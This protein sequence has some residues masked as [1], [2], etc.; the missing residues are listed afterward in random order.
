MSP[1]V[2]KKSAAQV[3]APPVERL[4]GSSQVEE[5]T[6]GAAQLPAHP[7]HQLAPL[8]LPLLPEDAQPRIPGGILPGKHPA[9]VRRLGEHQPDRLPQ[10]PGQVRHRGVHRNHQVQKRDQRGGI[11]E[12]PDPSSQVEEFQPRRGG[13]SL[14]GSRAKL[15]GVELHPRD[16]AQRGQGFQGAGAEGIRHGFPAPDDPHSESVAPR[17][18]GAPVGDPIGRRA[19]VGK[20]RRDVLQSGTEDE[21]K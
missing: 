11:P 8:P 10:G 2:G 7:V 17:D 16:P 18:P 15:Q 19:Q 4:A 13:Q 14:G 1:L 9:P 5:G 20:L 12:I 3:G 6:G 21:G